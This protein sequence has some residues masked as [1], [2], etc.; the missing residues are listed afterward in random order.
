[1]SETEEDVR[2]GHLSDV[3]CKTKSIALAGDLLSS[4]PSP[5]IAVVETGR[6]IHVLG[7]E[8]GLVVEVR[9]GRKQGRK[10]GRMDGG[11][12]KEYT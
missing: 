3:R 8:K 7:F 2:K 9:G 4:S 10:Q 11:K 6:G 12:E 5:R 1:M